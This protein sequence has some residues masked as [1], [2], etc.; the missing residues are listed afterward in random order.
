MLEVTALL[1]RQAG[2][3]EQARTCEREPDL[4]LPDVVEELRKRLRA[5]DCVESG[6]ARLTNGLLVRAE[7]ESRRVV[8]GDDCLAVG[9]GLEKPLADPLRIRE[10]LDERAIV[11]RQGER[12]KV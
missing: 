3:P 6:G 10:E 8:G 12:S 5:D 9:A 7:F 11:E 1:V 4:V 2:P